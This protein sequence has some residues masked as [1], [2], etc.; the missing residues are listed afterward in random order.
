MNITKGFA[1]RWISKKGDEQ[2]REN[3]TS[4]RNTREWGYRSVMNNS[5]EKHVGNTRSSRK[6]SIG[7]EERTIGGDETI[8]EKKS[9]DNTQS[10]QKVSIGRPRSIFNNRVQVLEKQQWKGSPPDGITIAL[11]NYTPPGQFLK[12][13]LSFFMDLRKFWRRGV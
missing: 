10:S 5:P 4:V 8:A 6:D 3:L 1:Y 11:H 9:V 13:I 2:C 7:R 12:S